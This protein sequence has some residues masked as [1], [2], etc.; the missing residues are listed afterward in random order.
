[1]LKK[2]APCFEYLS[3][4]SWYAVT[5]PFFF[6]LLFVTPYPTMKFFSATALAVAS[7][8]AVATASSSDPTGLPGRAELGPLLRSIADWILTT[9]VQSNNITNNKDSLKTSI[10][11]NGNLAR[12]ALAASI[13]FD[14]NATYREAGLEWCD[15]LV[16][17]Q[18][19]QSTHD[20]RAGAAGWWDTGYHELYIADTGTAVT[21]LALCY[22]FVR[23]EAH[24]VTKDVDVVAR[25]S[26]PRADAYMS[27]MTRFADFV[28]NGTATTPKC[29]FSPGE[30]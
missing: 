18:H 23:D 11:I 12:V 14:N 13:I 9:D 24:T 7:T 17:Q 1:M 21:T 6:S 10:F 28:V 3:I 8:A 25:K 4:C 26:S 20:G 19:I 5:A 30:W 22:D 29:D 16:K 15:T 27:A 2:M